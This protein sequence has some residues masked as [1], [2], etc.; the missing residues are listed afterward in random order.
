MESSVPEDGSLQPRVRLHNACLACQKRKSKCDG[1]HPSCCQCQKRGIQ[2][3]YQQRRF[4]GPGKS[5]EFA[6][7]LEERLKR[8]EESLKSGTSSSTDEGHG[9]HVEDS[10]PPLPDSRTQ[11]PTSTTFTQANALSQNPTAL[12][13]SPL[14]RLCITESSANQQQLG[15][16]TASFLQMHFIEFIRSTVKTDTFK[17]SL[18]SPPH[19]YNKVLTR[20]E[21]I[22]QDISDLYPLLEM[23]HLQELITPQE[24]DDFVERSA[25]MAICNASLALGV[26]CKTANSAYG[27]LAPAS[28]AYVKSAFS[29]VP[30]LLFQGSSELAYEAMLIVA[31]FM[32]GNADL[33]I[34][35][36][37][38][39]LAVRAYQMRELSRS[40][41]GCVQ[42]TEIQLR[43]FW[44]L[45][46]LDIDLAF[47]IGIP[48]M[49][50]DLSGKDF[51]A[52]T[53]LDPAWY[54]EVPG[55][56]H[57]VNIMRHRAELTRIQH[58]VYHQLPSSTA[59]HPSWQDLSMRA[60]ILH[61]DLEKW[62]MNMPA[63]FRPHEQYQPGR[64]NLPLPVILMHFIYHDLKMKMQRM[65]GFTSVGDCTTSAQATI[66]LMHCLP[67][68]QFAALWRVLVYP[69]SAALVLLAAASNDTTGLN[70]E[71]SVNGIRELTHY[72][73]DMLLRKGC[74]LEKALPW[75]SRFESVAAAIS[76]GDTAHEIREVHKSL[77]QVL[78]S[79]L[80]YLRLAQSFFGRMT[81][82]DAVRI[83]ELS[84]TLQI[85]WSPEDEFGPFVPDVLKPRTHNFDFTFA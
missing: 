30:L 12:H 47:R 75:F 74:D 39:T 19:S 20:L 34:A 3:V 37:L 5:K 4:R 23:S 83:Q 10:P 63:S 84:E 32:L 71:P 57:G 11:E 67:T 55:M 29:T 35:S 44:T 36:H 18:F 6:H 14:E 59:K 7:K 76:A 65:K 24:S 42:D 15:N 2:C 50:S 43:V 60:E 22:V 1:Q 64:E 66:R 61:R 56:D 28:W 85:C 51:P 49:I 62:K 69:T 48:P 13:M 33:H 17:M 41:Q 31:I 40:H 46:S 26:Q 68:Q 25:R 70:A 78:S 82:D 80:D 8:L 27:E 54:L 52:E 58:D 79:D 73:S 16:P 77:S 21:D 53:P 81:V 9:D 45:A 72:L 38:N